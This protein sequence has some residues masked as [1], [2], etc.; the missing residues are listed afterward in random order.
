MHISEMQWKIRKK[1]FV[2]EI[3]VFELVARCAP[4]REYLLSAVNV[5]KNSQRFLQTNRL[6]TQYIPNAWKNRIIVVPC[7]QQETVNI[8]YDL[9]KQDLLD[10]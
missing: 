10:V 9:L 8:D 6:L 2:F 5:L 3:M 7:F 1:T 4:Q